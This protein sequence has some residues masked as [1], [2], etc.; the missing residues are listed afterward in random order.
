MHSS[1]VQRSLKFTKTL[2]LDFKV[3]QGHRCQYPW[4]G[5]CYDN[6][7]VFVYLQ[8]FSCYESTVAEIVHL[9]RVLKFDAVVR[10][11]P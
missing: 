11:T 2:Y 5:A 4:K 1:N 3:V 7:Q 6:Q 9:E 10:R 8:P